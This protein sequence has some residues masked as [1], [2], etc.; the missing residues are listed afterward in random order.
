[1]A[2]PG[3][4]HSQEGPEQ[5]RRIDEKAAAWAEENAAEALEQ[6]SG[7]KGAAIRL[8]K[9]I[10]KVSRVIPE[11]EQRWRQPTQQKWSQL[12]TVIQDDVSAEREY[13][14]KVCRTADDGKRQ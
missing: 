12:M 9:W 5:D 8:E 13:Q 3:Q 11:L 1:M 14:K 4:G 6:R 2:A 10:A 7:P